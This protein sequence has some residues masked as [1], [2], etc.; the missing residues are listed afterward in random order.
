MLLFK[1]YAVQLD[2]RGLAEVSDT[3]LL[4]GA[5]WSVNR[6]VAH[7]LGSD[8]FR[9]AIYRLALEFIQLAAIFIKSADSSQLRL[10]RCQIDEFYQVVVEAVGQIVLTDLFPRYQLK[11]VLIDI[12][13]Y[14]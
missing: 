11:R 10:S 6:E 13:D 7:L 4:V 2:L 14:L 8:E 12:P 9:L 3:H 1:A 5:T